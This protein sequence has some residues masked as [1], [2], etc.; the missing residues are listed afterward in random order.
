MPPKMKICERCNEEKPATHQ[1]FGTNFRMPDQLSP[2]CLMCRYAVLVER[3]K[4]KN[5]KSRDWANANRE[6]VR[7]INRRTYENNKQERLAY[8]R[9]WRKKNR[10]RINEYQ[11]AYAE[12]KR[13]EQETASDQSC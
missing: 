13:G 6:K 8:M 9:Q 7:E 12:K 1:Y 11:R 2:H 4:R 3:R 10:E 5:E